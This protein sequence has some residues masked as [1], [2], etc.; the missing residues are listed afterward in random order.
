MLSSIWEFLY[1]Y[2][3]ENQIV[4]TNYYKANGNVFYTIDDK[5][6]KKRY[7]PKI[8]GL[9]VIFRGKN[10]TLVI[11]ANPLP[12]FFNT[13]IS[14]TADNNFFEIESSK[15]K[16]Q[17]S[18]FYS[19]SNNGTLFINKNL[20]CG[21]VKIV[22]GKEAN[23]KLTIGENC[24]FSTGIYIRT[25][26][27]HTLYDLE[28]KKPLNP[29]KNVVIENNVWLCEG[30]KVLKGA[31]ISEQ[32]V[33]AAG[34]IVTKEFKKTNV[35]LSGIPAKISRENIGVDRLPYDKYCEKNNIQIDE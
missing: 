32:T 21:S 34:S 7:F 35:V 33:V 3:P 6:G 15:Y 31:Y 4:R 9:N 29:P 1:K 23:A 27:A 19:N 17:Y 8:K 5:T 14:I 12:E 25:S 2:L 11:H 22:L 20:Y 30:V 26:D 13:T 28:T 16:I 10:S 18:K 24:L